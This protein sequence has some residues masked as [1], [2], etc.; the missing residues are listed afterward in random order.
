[1]SNFKCLTQGRFCKVKL[2]LKINKNNLFKLVDVLFYSGAISQGPKVERGLEFEGFNL[3]KCRVTFQQS[4][5]NKF[6]ACNGDAVF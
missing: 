1:M 4:K 2:T 6:F 5:L 3:H